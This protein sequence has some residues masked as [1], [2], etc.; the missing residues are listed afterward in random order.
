ML[1]RDIKDGPSPIAKTIEPSAAAGG[2]AGGRADGDGRA[3]GSGAARKRKHAELLKAAAST[4][5]TISN[6]KTPKRCRKGIL[7]KV[8]FDNSSNS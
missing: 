3:G 2:L 6:K 5:T 8:R 1:S 7:N 4:K